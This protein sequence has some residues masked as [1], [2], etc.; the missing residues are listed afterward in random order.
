MSFKVEQLDE[1][2]MV[3][4][5]IETSAEEFEKGLNAAYN[6]EK[7]RINVPG[8][9]KGKAPRKIIERMYGSEVFYESAA[10][11]IIPEAYAN[12]AD[13]SKLDLVSQPS[14]NVVTLEAGKPFVFEATV[15]VRPEVELPQYKGVEVEKVDTEVTDEDVEAEVKKALDQNAR[16]VD[17]FD[18]AVKD[19]DM[20]TIDF[21]GFIDGEAFDGGKGEDYPLTI[22]SHSFIGDFEEQ[23]IG[24]NLDEEK[25]I[26][27]TF[28]EDYHAENLKG[29]PAMF[30]VKIKA[31]KE[32]QLPE[33][34]D[35]FAQDVSDFDTLAEYKED[36]KKKVADRK[37]AE[38]KSK[39]Q[40][41]VI[42]KIVE[43]AK[44]DIP[45]AMIDTQVNR[46]A[47]DFAQR[48]QQQGL[49]LEQYFQYTG[50]TPEKI[51]DDMK[52]EALKRIKNSLVLEAIVKAEGIEASDEDI[53]AE[54]TKM[55][56]MY[57][58]D[59]EK[60]KANMGEEDKKQMG[61]DIAIQKVVDLLVESAVE[62]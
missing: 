9:R 54:V 42:D 30:K 22:G 47:E 34:N 17:V 44:M 11:A 38:G 19:G 43:E 58:M 23:L 56:D 10:N 4:L 13:E 3:K 26:N 61:A 57:K 46:M 2:N 8:F 48:L 16:T 29:K 18:R 28:P 24:L 59:A 15:A 7:S 20:T 40:N 14:I 12:A 31:I 6:K 55:A 37:A 51:I 32:K 5:V 1:K 21:E 25:E 50:L 39:K 45:Q 62:K 35:E 27:V 53:D 41:E 33:L 36:L 60:L 52:P 49:S